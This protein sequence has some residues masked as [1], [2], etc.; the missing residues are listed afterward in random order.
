MVGQVRR[1]GEVHGFAWIVAL[2]DP[3]GNAAQ[4]RQPARICGH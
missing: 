3:D 1:S 4:I 2:R